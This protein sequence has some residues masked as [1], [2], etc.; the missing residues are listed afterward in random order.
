MS[1]AYLDDFSARDVRDRRRFRRRIVQGLGGLLIMI[2]AGVL[3]G[4]FDDPTAARVE[5]MET[6]ILG[7]VGAILTF[8]GHYCWLGSVESRQQL[9][10][11]QAVTN[12]RPHTPTREID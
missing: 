6:A 12:R 7:I 10:G 8:I 2:V 4:L 1:N 11:A 3:W 9:S 5:Q